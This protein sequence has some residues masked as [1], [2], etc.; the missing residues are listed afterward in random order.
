MPEAPD[1]A[2]TCSAT[3]RG[4]RATRVAFASV[5]ASA[6]TSELKAAKS[7]HLVA[8]SDRRN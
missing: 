7:D 4:E 3:A 2:R 1:F 6:R 8:V 5:S